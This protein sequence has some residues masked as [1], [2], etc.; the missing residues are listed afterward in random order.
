[1]KI[2][3]KI[4]KNVQR[5]LVEFE[6]N[7]KIRV[8]VKLK[9]HVEKAKEIGF[10]K[11][12]EKGECIVPNSSVSKKAM[13]NAE[14][15][16]I[17]RRDLPKEFAERY[18]QWSWKDYG[19]NEHWDFRYIP[20][21]RYVQ[22]YTKPKLL[23]FTIMEDELNEKWI[24]SKIF[25]N[26]DKEHSDIKEIVN[27]FLSVFGEC[28][29]M[30]NNLKN[31]VKLLKYLPWELLRKGEGTKDRLEE[32][33]NQT[34]GE[35]KKNMYR[36]NIKKLLETSDDTVAVG[37]AEFR[38]YIAFTYSKKNIAVLESLMPNNATYV[39]D[40]NWQEISKMT[41]TEIINN[42]SYIERIYH[43]SDWEQRIEKCIS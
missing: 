43:Y 39:L 40:K 15:K 17:I 24:V 13:E 35:N 32:I 5:Y 11:D 23:N 2:Q 33:I 12:F 1:M 18:H 10:S 26:N 31:P 3:K 27:L 30:K 41:K 4:I 21:L 16:K 29:I 6:E 14:G 36:R 7:E 42:K 34:T 37:K 25:I 22:E 28:Y 8:G 38:G 9:E 20:Y 19:G